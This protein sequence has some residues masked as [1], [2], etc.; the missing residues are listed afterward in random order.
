MPKFDENKDVQ[1]SGRVAKAA[2]KIDD[3]MDHPTQ[4]GKILKE[5]ERQTDSVAAKYLDP[6]ELADSRSA[7]RGMPLDDNYVDGSRTENPDEQAKS[8]MDALPRTLKVWEE[9]LEAAL[10]VLDDTP[11]SEEKLVE[12]METYAKGS[13]NL[14]KYMLAEQKQHLMEMSEKA[15]EVLFE[16]QIERGDVDAAYKT[17]ETK[18]SIDAH[19]TFGAPPPHRHLLRDLQKMVDFCHQYHRKDAWYWEDILKQEREK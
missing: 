16:R 10:K 7:A 8:Q 6:L 18:L 19:L 1:D 14:A 17:L 13:H 2:L 11:K 9:R 12:Q 15:F 4:T 5:S 3:V